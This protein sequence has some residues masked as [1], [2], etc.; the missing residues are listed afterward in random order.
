MGSRGSWG[1]ASAGRYRFVSSFRDREVGG[2]GDKGRRPRGEPLADGF[3][4]RGNGAMR[5]SRCVSVRAPRPRPGAAGTSVMLP[6]FSWARP[7]RT[8]G[9]VGSHSTFKFC[10]LS[11]ASISGWP[12]SSIALHSTAVATTNASAYAIACFDFS[13]AARRTRRVRRRL[14]QA[15]AEPPRRR[16]RPEAMRRRRDGPYRFASRRCSARCSFSAFVPFA[17]PRR[18]RHPACRRD[19]RACVRGASTT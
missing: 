14:H 18:A 17:A 11:R 7:E 2:G 19:C 6:R 8:S 12:V 1:D 13:S 10:S 16:A 15:N 4:E 9:R 5:R 3:Q